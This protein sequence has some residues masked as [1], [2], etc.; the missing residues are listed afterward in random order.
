PGFEFRTLG[1]GTQNSPY[2]VSG[3]FH[4]AGRVLATGSREGVKLWDVR[5]CRELLSHSLRSVHT[6]RF[7]P[8][9]KMLLASGTF[10]LAGWPVVDGIGDGPM[11]LA[12]ERETRISRLVECM[13]FG[14][15]R[16]SKRVAAATSGRVMVLNLDTS[17]ETLAGE[18]TDGHP[19]ARYAD[20]S[21]DGQWAATGTWKGRDVQ[22]WRLSDHKRFSLPIADNAGVSFSP[23]SR[24]LITGT[25]QRYQ[26]WKVGTWELLETLSRDS[27]ADVPG[28]ALFTRDGKMW[29][30]FIGRSG[31]LQLR[32]GR[33]NSVLANVE[34]GPLWPLAFSSDGSQLAVRSEQGM[35]HVW[36]LRRVN[37]QL[38]RLSLAEGLPTYGN[39]D[40]AAMLKTA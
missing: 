39:V 8:D 29:S 5:E 20:I 9:G 6:V 18:F 19:N 26:T 21:P 14:I 23:D 13:E 33:S 37:R 10:G 16:E 28:P 1:S 17:A 27:G 12:L 25:G 38:A 22:V 7:T 31:G 30:V 2:E 36:D 11:R 40:D 15:D 34:A 35:V 3:D 4:P 32:D 24:R